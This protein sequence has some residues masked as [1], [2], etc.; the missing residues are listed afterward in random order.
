MIIF[1]PNNE[2]WALFLDIFFLV[3][4]G[5]GNIKE[6][7]DGTSPHLFSFTTYVTFTH[8]LISRRFL[9]IYLEIF[10]VSC[11]SFWSMCQG[12]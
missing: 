12:S 3:L 10:E 4:L 5:S 1:E 8:T 6:Q 7:E 9:R 2:I 11:K